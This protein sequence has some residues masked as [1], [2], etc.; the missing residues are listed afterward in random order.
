MT[1]CEWFARC[2]REAAG[3]VSHPVLG[4]VPTCQ[5]CAVMLDLDLQPPP[6]DPWPTIERNVPVTPALLRRF[7]GRNWCFGYNGH[8]IY[9]LSGRYYAVTRKGDA[10][11][12]TARTAGETGQEC[13]D[14]IALLSEWEG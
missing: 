14:L 2:T 6:A 13:Q 10:L 12:I 11:V 4:D 8:S 5:P 7:V 9:V 3:V 1:T